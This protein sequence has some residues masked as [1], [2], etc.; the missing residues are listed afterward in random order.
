MDCSPARVFADFDSSSAAGTAQQVPALFVASIR[1]GFM[2][3]RISSPSASLSGRRVVV[4]GLGTFGGGIGA[5]R[6]LV[7]QQ[8]L[9]TVCDRRSESQLAGSIAQLA[10]T[11]PAG[12]ILGREHRPEDFDQADLIVVSPA[13]DPQ[14]PLLCAARE[15]GV[16]ISSEIEL[17][18]ERL[19][20]KTICV[21]GSNGKS[22][23]TSLIAHLLSQQSAQRVWLGGNIGQSLLPVVDQISPADLVVLELSSFQL[24]QLARLS[25]APDVAVVTNFSP[26]HLDRHGSL[27]AYRAAK[28]QLLRWQRPDQVAVLNADDAD[29][30]SWPGSARRVGFGRLRS[31]RPGVWSCPREPAEMGSAEAALTRWSARIQ[32]AG[33]AEEWQLYE[34]PLGDWSPL[35]GD[36]N[37]ENVLAAVAVAVEI[38]LS[39]E[40]IA[41]GLRSFRGLSHRL[42]LVAEFEGRRFI[43]DSKATTPEAAIR[44]LRSFT[45]PVWHLAGGYNKQVEL[46]ELVQALQQPQVRGIACL[47]QTG[48]ILHERLSRG[49]PPANCRRFDSL[50]EAVEWCAA[51]S[52]PGEV[53]LLS[54]GCAST[55]QFEN[56]EARGERFRQCVQSWIH[57]QEQP[58][59]GNGGGHG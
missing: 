35:P 4:L 15:R 12:W 46:T 21:T 5:V 16:A 19:Q 27:E 36:H 54:P 13:V 49:S 48:P 47:G 43:N 7:Q 31:V 32:T 2:S 58:P 45:Q 29:V 56:Y 57:R 37:R 50:D 34:W 42:E 41:A 28:Q 40:Q 39:R 51:A 6:Y 9:V 30:W 1:N 18:W 17:L 20:A 33:T 25:P 44:A 59:A 24:E 55:D 10:D 11:P 22:T 53:V 8:A 38:G 26:N 52:Q 3:L 23:T 14:L